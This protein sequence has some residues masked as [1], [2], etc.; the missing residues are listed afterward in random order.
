MSDIDWIPQE[1]GT[2]Y[3]QVETHRGTKDYLQGGRCVRLI[4]VKPLD[5]STDTLLADVTTFTI[6]IDF[7]IFS[8]LEFGVSY[9][10]SVS[11]EGRKGIEE[12]DADPRLAAQ[13]LRLDVKYTRKEKN[14][15]YPTFS[16]DLPR[17]F[18]VVSLQPHGGP[19]I[20]A[21]PVTYFAGG[22]TQGSVSEEWPFGDNG[23]SNQGFIFDTFHVGQGM[24]SLVHDEHQGILLDM[25]AG[26]PVTRDV[27]QRK[28]INNDLSTLVSAMRLL[29]V[30]SHADSDHW[31]ILAWDPALLSKIDKIY[32]PSGAISLAMQDK[33]VN[34]KIHGLSDTTWHLSSNTTIQFWKS[35][36]SCDDENGRCL[37]AVFD[38]DGDQVLV[39][40]DYVYKRFKSDANNGINTL[41]KSRYLAVVVPHH[42]DEASAQDVIPPAGVDAKAFFSAGTHQGWRHPTD[43][44]LKAHEN[45][46]FKNI[47]DPVQTNIVRVNLI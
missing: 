2:F 11:P 10:R 32:A 16:T 46:K 28:L 19:T 4:A 26:K 18:E 3:C 1:E 8:T 38:R 47:S 22:T 43:N 37:V 24:C 30:I 12:R 29:L 15:L 41:H 13:W 21:L 45:A 31:R 44:S 5:F 34:K 25:G 39:P 20:P 36:P 33:A 23:Q 27:Y 42:G 35:E 40:G 14:Y 6:D 7:W 9:W 17:F